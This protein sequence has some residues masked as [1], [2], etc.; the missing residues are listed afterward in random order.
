M[1]GVARLGRQH[2]FSTAVLQSKV[3]VGSKWLLHNHGSF[4]ALQPLETCILMPV[5]NRRFTLPVGDTMKF[6]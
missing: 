5:G 3:I 2:G 1:P 6:N 4:P